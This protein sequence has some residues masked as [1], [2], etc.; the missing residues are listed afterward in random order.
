[1]GFINSMKANL[2]KTVGR[3]GRGANKVANHYAPIASKAIRRGLK[4]ANDFG[5]TAQRLVGHIGQGATAAAGLAGA[6]STGNIPGGLASGKLLIGSIK[7][8]VKEVKGALRRRKGVDRTIKPGKMKPGD[9]TQGG[10][11][12]SGD[13]ASELK[14]VSG[15]AG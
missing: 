12:I 9:L 4:F 10:S 14:K 15:S 6:I 5:G 7:G 13:L 8:A 3:I 2:L 11:G 1:M